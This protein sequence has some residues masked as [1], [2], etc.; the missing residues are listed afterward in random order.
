MIHRS[1]LAPAVVVALGAILSAAATRAE[2]VD[3]V[4][5]EAGLVQVNCAAPV[6]VDTPMGGVK[7]S[8]YGYEG[9]ARGIEE[10]LLQKLVHRPERGA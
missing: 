9:G 3:P 10:Y 6:R 1:S 2:I 8:G 4:A 7:Q 5:L